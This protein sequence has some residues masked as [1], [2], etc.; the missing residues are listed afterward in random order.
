MERR[1]NWPKLF[2]NLPNLITVGRLLLA[3]LAVDMILS[4]RFV[5]AFTIFVVAGVSDGIDGWLAKR[6]RLAS[7]LGALLDPLAD[8]VLLDAIYVTLAAIA[9]LPPWLPILVVS[10]DLMILAAVVLSRWMAKPIAIRPA[11]ISKINTA[12]QIAFA[13]FLLGS[14]AFGL[15]A[16]FAQSICAGV[17]AASTL[18]SGAVYIRQ[19]LDHMSR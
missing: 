19:W 5:A 3:P 4:Q 12:L 6:F 8:K 7:E 2:A 1:M 18:A 17:V 9:E 13:A 14:R 16:P 15:D 10:R 11:L